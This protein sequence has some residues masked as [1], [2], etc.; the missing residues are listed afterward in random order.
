MIFVN[1]DDFGKS[2]EITDAILIS[3]SRG[4][5]DYASLMVNMPDAVRAMEIA[6]E[7]NIEKRIGLHLNIS[8]GYPITEEIRKC[9]IFCDVE[10]GMFNRKF[11]KVLL[12]RFLLKPYEARL[13]SKEIEA[14][15]LLYKSLGGKGCRIDS[16]HHTHKDYCVLRI[17]LPLVRK[18]GFKYIRIAKDDGK[19]INCLYNRLM[20]MYISINRKPLKASDILL[21]SL[22]E[23]IRKVQLFDGKVIEI[24]VHPECINDVLI[25]HASGNE[26]KVKLNHVLDIIK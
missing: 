9:P 7:R 23:G 13:L 17:L 24:E 18:Y 22:A 11:Q 19:G 26:K 15:I 14:Q 16:H 3:F 6:K 8:E 25:D 5:V 4:F 10:T 12:S 1:A 20:N 2:K 21:H